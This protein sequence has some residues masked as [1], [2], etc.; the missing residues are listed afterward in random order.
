FL[1]HVL[2]QVLV[3]DI[4]R[5]FEDIVR[6]TPGGLYNSPHILEQETALNLDSRRNLA[7]G[8]VRSKNRTAGEKRSDPAGVRDWVSVDEA[9]N[10]YALALAHTS[11]VYRATSP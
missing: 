2:T 3:P 11:R 5:H 10:F 6:G 8:G 9:G 1:V 7:C 4:N